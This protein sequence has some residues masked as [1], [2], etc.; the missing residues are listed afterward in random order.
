MLFKI[1]MEKSYIQLLSK[2]RSAI[3]GVAILWVMMFHIPYKLEVP[4]LMQ[5]M[6]I[7]YGG[8]DIFLLLSGFGLSFSLSKK[9]FSLSRYYKSRACRI[10]PESWFYLVITYIIAGEYTICSFEALLCKASTIG[11]WIPGIPFELWYISCIVVFYAFFPFFFKQLKKNMVKTVLTGI[12]GG[13]MLTIIYAIIMV[14]V[15]DNE[16][17]GGYMIMAISRIPV[18]VIGAC[19]GLMAKSKA[20]ICVS[21][22]GKISALTAFFLGF[23]SLF[24]CMLFLKPYLW[25]CALYWIPFILITPVLCILLAVLFEKLPFPLSKAFGFVGLMSYEL[26]ILH[27]Y[28]FKNY[29]D[30]IVCQYSENV[31]NV[32]LVVISFIFAYVFYLFNKYVLQRLVMRILSL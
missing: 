23:L 27:C 16:N 18:F 30:I 17:K 6:A 22:A 13:L 15:F 9:D 20:N 11:L 28:F 5:L 26:Y 14:C 21:R 1:G 29:T 19:L 10:L 12:G 4:G 25:T 24:I 8:V 2:H 7:G 3:M 32:I 31:T